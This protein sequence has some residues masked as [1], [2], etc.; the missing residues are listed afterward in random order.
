MGPE[1]VDEAQRPF[2]PAQGAWLLHRPWLV[3]FL[4]GLPVVG[5][6]ALVLAITGD[7]I[8]VRELIPSWP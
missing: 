7:V 1:A 2:V 5:V 3:I 8:L 6:S 4:A